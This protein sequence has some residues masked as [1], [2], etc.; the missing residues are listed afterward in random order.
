MLIGK[1]EDIILFYYF[2]H[3]S[4]RQGHLPNLELVF[5]WLSGKPA[6]SSDPLV[7]VYIEGE[8]IKVHWRAQ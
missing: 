5:S 4:L 3:I 2:L 8:F 1:K 7:S 6:S